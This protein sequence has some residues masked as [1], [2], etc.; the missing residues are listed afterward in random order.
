MPPEPAIA[1]RAPGRGM[2]REL[3]SLWRLQRR[4]FPERCCSLSTTVG[5]SEQSLPDTDWL[6]MGRVCTPKLASMEIQTELCMPISLWVGAKVAAPLLIGLGLLVPFPLRAAEKR[7]EQPRCSFLSADHVPFGLGFNVSGAQS[8]RFQA[9][10]P[11]GPARSRPSGHTSGQLRHSRVSLV[12]QQTPSS[13]RRRVW[14]PESV[15]SGAADPWRAGYR[16]TMLS[17]A[18]PGR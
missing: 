18:A 16:C 1:E 5:L 3:R 4:F 9:V 7:P 15:L 17:I 10:C 8:S 6:R 2:L 13:R 12:F 14:S 11:A